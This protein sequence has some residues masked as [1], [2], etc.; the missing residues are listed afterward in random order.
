MHVILRGTISKGNMKPKSWVT[1][2]MDGLICSGTT[3]SSLRNLM[4][5]DISA[6]CGHSW[7][8]SMQVQLMTAGNFLPRIRSVDPTVIATIKIKIQFVWVFQSS[9]KVLHTWR[10]TQNDFQLTS[11]SI[12]EELPAVV[13]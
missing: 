2:E 10:E 8:Q 6:S 7:N 1:C 3:S 9:E 4:D 12:Y 13:L 11:N 5:T